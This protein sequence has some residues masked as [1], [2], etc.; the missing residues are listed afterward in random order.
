LIDQINCHP[1]CSLCNSVLLVEQ[2]DCLSLCCA[3]WYV[4]HL[5]W[6]ENHAFV[7]L[8]FVVKSCRWL[9][10]FLGSCLSYISYHVC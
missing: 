7:A 10:G 6:L 9:V 2:I 4:L 8:C 3:Y 1:P 5:G